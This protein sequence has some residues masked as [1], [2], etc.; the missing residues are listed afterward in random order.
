MDPACAEN[1]VVLFILIQFS[2]TH[3]LL[4]TFYAMLQKNVLAF[5]NNGFLL[6]MLA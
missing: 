4:R 1:T 6:T 5:V 3:P 2:F